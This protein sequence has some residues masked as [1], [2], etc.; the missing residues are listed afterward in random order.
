MS[1][2]SRI[3]S[4]E[5]HIGN[6]YNK[7]DDLG[8]DLTNVDKNID[9]I[10]EMLDTV[11]EEYPKVTGTGTEITLDGT[12]VG[13]LGLDIKGNSTQENSILPSGYTQVEY[14]ESSETQYI[15]TGFKPN[16]DTKLEIDYKYIDDGI[17]RHDWSAFG[18]NELFV[19]SS[20]NISP[21]LFKYNSTKYTS[22]VSTL[23]RHK[24]KFDKNNV[25]V[26]GNLI[27][28][29]TY[30]TFQANYNA[31]LFARRA[32]SNGAL[33]ERSKMQLYDC[34]I[35]DNNVLIRHFIPC[36]R[37]SDNEVGLYDLVNDVFYTNQ[38]TGTFT[39]GSTVSI[40]NPSYPQPI[41]SAGDNGTISEKIENAD[42]TQSQTY[43]IPCQQPMR[44]IG[45]VR[46]EFVKV[47]GEWKERHNIFSKIF[48]GTETVTKSAYAT[49]EYFCGYANIG[50]TSVLS[51]QSKCSHFSFGRYTDTST[52]ECYYI[53]NANINGTFNFKILA[54]RL[55]ANTVAGVKAW[56][57]EQYEN[58]T[59]V[60]LIAAMST[61]TNLPCTEEQ[62]SILENLPKSYNEQTNIYSLDVTPAYIEAKA[63]KGE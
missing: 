37:N 58:G 28:T 24:V 9:N 63:L 25:Y 7:L 22:T 52:G 41:L 51:G 5:E 38:G 11:Y 6:A 17:T 16:Q 47:N 13:K 60:T 1:I 19:L 10:A 14:I 2:S 35:Y 48:N 36:K 4:I 59:P 39:A 32:N 46:D 53:A 3:T 20:S 31:L 15:D 56:L 18:V 30:S 49:D 61:P 54:S 26:D 27:Y 40:P 44:S 62:I 42:G 57:K 29:F 23:E 8:I 21:M 45:D 50:N 12:K 55:S 34:K 43:T 33:Q